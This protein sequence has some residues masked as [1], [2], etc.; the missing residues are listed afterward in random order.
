M[1]TEAA[2][3]RA[4]KSL[5]AAEFPDVSP[6]YAWNVQFEDGQNHYRQMARAV[7]DALREGTGVTSAEPPEVRYVDTDTEKEVLD[8]VVARNASVHL[9]AMDDNH[10]W[11]SITSGGEMIHVNLYTKRAKITAHAEVQ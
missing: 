9:E 3:E 10:W 7:I 1:F 5:C 6:S 2:V 11:M 8:E 4:A